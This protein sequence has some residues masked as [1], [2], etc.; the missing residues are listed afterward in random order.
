[1]K[2]QNINYI[3]IVSPDGLKETQDTFNITIITNINIET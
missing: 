3:S 2:G 1:M